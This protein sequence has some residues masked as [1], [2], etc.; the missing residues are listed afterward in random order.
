MIGG[1]L[2]TEH[3]RSGDYFYV[4]TGA[5]IVLS[6]LHT[7]AFRLGERLLL[8]D[9]ALM[10]MLPLT[11]V[12][13]ANAYGKDRLTTACTHGII[14]LCFG[15]TL[16]S[17]IALPGASTVAAIA[18][19]ILPPLMF[20]G[21]VHYLR[22]RPHNTLRLARLF[23]Y[24]GL[25]VSI[26]LILDEATRSRAT[27]GNPNYAAHYC[28][29]SIA[30][31]DATRPR[32]V[33]L[34]GMA[35]LLYG[36]Y[37]TA[38][39]GTI[40]GLAVYGGLRVWHSTSHLE[41]LR[42]QCIRVL[43]PVAAMAG[44]ILVKTGFLEA[45]SS[46]DAISLSRL[47]RSGGSREV[48]WE[49]ALEVW[50]DHPLGIGFHTSL[51]NQPVFL[52]SANTEPHS[53]IIT[54]LLNGGFISVIGMVIIIVAILRRSSATSVPN[55]F[56]IAVLITGTVRQTW[57]FRHSW[58]ALAIIFAHELQSRQSPNTYRQGTAQTSPDSTQVQSPAPAE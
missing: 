42:R 20:L 27:F 17:T 40:L 50:R 26:L 18:R 28:L 5:A 9:L 48:L 10:V 8:A 23:I 36:I 35:L 52:G 24:T 33:L 19:E 3:H 51:D 56:L 41:S 1:Q 44:G 47:E 32:R 34:P 7:P 55:A 43:L 39:F 4:A 57:N 31:L 12:G 6:A 29:A 46:S 37:E 38:S 49:R 16:G 14:T 30:L 15:Y 11:L 13:V 54:A 22:F 2:P 58:I 53:D 25:L 21:I 45:Q